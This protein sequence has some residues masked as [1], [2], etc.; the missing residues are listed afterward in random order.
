MFAAEQLE[1]AGL[2]KARFISILIPSSRMMGR[3]PPVVPWG[4]A[5]PGSAAAAAGPVG[6]WVRV[7]GASATPALSPSPTQ[8]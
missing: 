7:I 1:S 5:E 2:L 8:P 6:F 4:R 3:R